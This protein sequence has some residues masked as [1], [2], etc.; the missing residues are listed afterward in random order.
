[1][2]HWITLAAFAAAGLVGVSLLYSQD[3][4]DANAMP[5]AQPMPAPQPEHEWLQRFVGEWEFTTQFHFDPDM[6]PIE[7]TGTEHVRSIGGFWIIAESE[8]EAMGS[9]MTFI[10]TLGYDQ[11]EGAY[12]GTAID[13]MSS[14]MVQYDG[15]VDDS[16]NF[17][18]RWRG[19]CPM[20]DGRVVEFRSTTEF[21]DPDHRVLTAES[22]GDDGEWQTAIVLE[23]HRKN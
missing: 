19:P 18:L 8:S 21:K 23:A 17:V 9:N 4:Q 7:I 22:R 3:R 14:A 5:E 10:M 13:S 12:T 15:E 2:K 6:P 16:D 1:M 20:H 11:D